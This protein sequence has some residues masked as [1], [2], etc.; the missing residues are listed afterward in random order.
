MNGLTKAIAKVPNSHEAMQNNLE[1]QSH[2]DNLFRL[3]EIDFKEITFWSNYQDIG[4]YFFKTLDEYLDIAIDIP[5]SQKFEDTTR[6]SSM[7]FGG[8]AGITR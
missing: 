8:Y 4:D 6:Y 3:P 5:D 2:I 1:K 7:D